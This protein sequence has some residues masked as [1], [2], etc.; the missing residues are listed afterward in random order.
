MIVYEND[1]CSCAVPGYPCTGKHKHVPHLH[2]DRCDAD[3]EEVYDVDGEDI[4]EECLLE[5]Y[6]KKTLE[7]LI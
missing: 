5:M 6:E 1:C 2:C 7:D 4:C 3:V